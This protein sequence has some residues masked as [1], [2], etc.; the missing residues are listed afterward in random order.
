VEGAEAIDRGSGGNEKRG[1]IPQPIATGII[2]REL[3]AETRDS[4]RDIGGEEE[5]RRIKKKNQEEEEEEEE[6]R[7]QGTVIETSEE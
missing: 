6:S 1:R 7:R 4:D 5:S 2:E 3:E